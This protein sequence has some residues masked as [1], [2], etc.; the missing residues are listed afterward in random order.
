MHFMVSDVKPTEATWNLSRVLTGHNFHYCYIK[1]WSIENEITNY[2]AMT[3]TNEAWICAYFQQLIVKCCK[4]HSA[5]L[6]RTLYRHQTYE[7]LKH[8][9]STDPKKTPNTKDGLP[10]LKRMYNIYMLRYQYTYITSTIEIAKQW[11]PFFQKVYEPKYLS[12]C[13]VKCQILP[14]STL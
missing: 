8:H 6:L 13:L 12:K 5:S 3:S 2:L 9:L 1:R 14:H 11:I 7:V 10:G 4:N